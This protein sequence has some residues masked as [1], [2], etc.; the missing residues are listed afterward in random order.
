MF[1]VAIARSH[2]RLICSLL[3]ELVADVGFYLMKSSSPWL[4]I[5]LP[6]LTRSMSHLLQTSLNPKFKLLHSR[7]TQSPTRSILL[8]FLAAISG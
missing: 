7:Q 5:V 4:M 3:V 6:T 8:D 1:T 2:T